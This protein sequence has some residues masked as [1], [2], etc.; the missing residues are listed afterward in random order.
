MN[1]RL[2]LDRLFIHGAAVRP[3]LARDTGLSLPTV[4]AALRDLEQAGLVRAAGRLE[5]AQGRP[6]AAYEADPTA[7][8][9]V[10]VD[11]GREK[12]RLLVTDLAG[13]PLSRLEVRNT[14][15]TAGA[16]VNQVEQ[17]VAD[18]TT[19]AGLEASD[20]THTVIGSPGVFDPQRGRIMYAANL[21]GWQRAGLAE[22]LT[23]R[24]GTA[25]TIDN[26]A[27]LAALG[28]HTYGAARG[29]RHF[30]YLTIGTGVGLGLVLDGR[31]YRG[32]S[33][34]AGEVGYL[35]I[36]DRIAEDHPSHPRRGMLEEAIAADAFVRH[37]LAQD[38]TGP[39]TAASIF[40]SAR[41]GDLRAQRA[42]A[43][44]AQNL[45]QLV[46]GILSFLDPELIVV[47]G[48]VGQNLDLL[49]PH[50][51]KALA[52]ITPMRPTMTA[53]ALGNEAVVRGAIATGITTA[54][55]T[56]FSARTKTS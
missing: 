1:Q 17:A 5:A 35:P 26:D 51:K 7:G 29:R 56:V 13:Q 18:A 14:A 49:E 25:L 12:L 55:E 48:G 41:D 44:V 21:P 37:G 36:G 32:H 38:M 20:V 47:G 6:A 28:E 31:L 8:S 11:I 33:G 9:V 53:S 10:G 24:L 45:G 30:A 34:A 42:I 39:L 23:E 2:L 43:A 50:I 4:I 22:T 52:L 54:R 40:T 16:L 15:R 46:A 27:N 19:Q 3:Q